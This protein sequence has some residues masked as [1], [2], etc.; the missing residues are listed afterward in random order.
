MRTA[1]CTSSQW[2]RR[3]PKIESMKRTFFV[4]ALFGVGI[5]CRPAATQEPADRDPSWLPDVARA[6]ALRASCA[7]GHDS[8]D[9]RDPAKCIAAWLVERNGADPTGRQACMMQARSCEAAHACEPSGDSSAMAFCAKHANPSTACD[10]NARIECGDDDGEAERTDCATLGGTCQVVRHSGGL[11]ESAC[12]STTACPPGAKE[13]RCENE[14]TVFACQDGAADR[15][16][17]QP[18]RKCVARKDD[19][20][21]E[22]ASCETIGAPRCSAPG[23]RYCEG[24]RLVSC[25][26]PRGNDKSSVE[27]TDCGA[28]G[29]RC[30]GQGK[31]AGCYVRGKP[32]CSIEDALT[33]DDGAMSYCVLGRRVRVACNSIGGSSCEG[34]TRIACQLPH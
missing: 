13:G 11:T 24:E 2:R 19:D 17:C 1:L 34:G 16:V 8:G 26:G 20:G 21:I 14:T 29:L 5:A 7:H 12:V 3:A 30:E 32:D 9:A 25:M 31:A 10:G 33:C 6:C 15:I 18:G 4:A 23:T 28:L 22:R 27:V